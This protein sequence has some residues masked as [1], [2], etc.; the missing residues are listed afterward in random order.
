[1][2]KGS[3]F[4]EVTLTLNCNDEKG[5]NENTVSG[6]TFL[7]QERSGKVLRV[8]TGLVCWNQWGVAKEATAGWSEAGKPDYVGVSSV[9]LTLSLK[10]RHWGVIASDCCPPS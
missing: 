8:G 10:K 7:E 1:M 3:L 9:G 6:R 4:E 5:T 2:A